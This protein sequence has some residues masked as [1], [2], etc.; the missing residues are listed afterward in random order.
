MV[1]GH[2]VPGDDADAHRNAGSRRGQALILILKSKNR[3]LQKEV[4]AQHRL[5]VVKWKAM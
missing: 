1:G 3:I 4:H 5:H 2:S